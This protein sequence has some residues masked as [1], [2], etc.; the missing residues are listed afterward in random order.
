MP[1]GV[2][3]IY[4]PSQEATSLLSQLAVKLII[5]AQGIDVARAFWFH[6]MASADFAQQLRGSTTTRLRSA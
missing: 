2:D 1:D 4:Q 3:R 6:I 5:K